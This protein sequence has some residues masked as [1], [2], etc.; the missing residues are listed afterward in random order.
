ATLND[1]INEPF[2]QFLELGPSSSVLDVGCGLGILTRRLA[3]IL[4][5]GEV[6]G[7]DTSAEQLSR[8]KEDRPNLRF[9]KANAHALPFEEN[10]FDV[11][12]CRFLLE[13]VA[14]PVGVLREMRRV[15]KPGGRAFVQ[16]NNIVANTFDPD[17][18]HFDA[19]WRRFAQLQTL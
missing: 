5:S 12:F 7:A 4:P 14:D 17:C 11:V 13:H 9:L 6:W 10:R 18:P 15:L 19:L 8:A 1:L 3:E 16:E 2:L